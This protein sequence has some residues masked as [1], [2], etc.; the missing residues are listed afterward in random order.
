MLVWQNMHS[1]TRLSF[2]GGRDSTV[3]NSVAE[4]ESIDLRLLAITDHIDVIDSGREVMIQQNR[5]ELAMLETDVKVLIGSELSLVDPTTLPVPDDFFETL[6]IALVSAN[7]FHV[8]GV[9]NPERRTEEA[10]ADWFLT[11]AEGAIRLGA[12]IIPHPFA[13]IGVKK[14]EGDRAVDMDRVLGSYDRARMR[15]LLGLAAEVGTAFELN[16]GY[17]RRYEEFFSELIEMAQKEGAWFSVGSD[18][19]HPGSI[20]YG[21]S[22]NVQEIDEMYRRLGLT[23]EDICPEYRVRRD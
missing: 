1:H 12:S 11:M 6:D 19:H 23:E 13:Y 2:C 15:E 7:H 18:G 5:D 21:G 3:A 22:E 4:A 16:P 17:V 14:L 20:H 10:Y 8:P 9:L